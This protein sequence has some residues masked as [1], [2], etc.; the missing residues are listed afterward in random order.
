MLKYETKSQKALKPNNLSKA[1]E[2]QIK[3]S[4]KY[5]LVR[6]TKTLMQSIKH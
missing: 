4:I 1:L 2:Y 5:M 3:L 6:I